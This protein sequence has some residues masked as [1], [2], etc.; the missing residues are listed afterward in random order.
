[1]KPEKEKRK[2]RDYLIQEIK[3]SG[4]PL[5]IEVS[6][7]LEKNYLVLNT[8]YYFDEE[9]REERN[10]DIYAIPRGLP[11]IDSKQRKNTFILQT[12]MAI[13]CKK[14]ET[15]AWIFY[16]RPNSSRWDKITGQYKTTVP[17]VLVGARSLSKLPHTFDEAL[18]HTCLGR[19]L[20]HD[21]PK[22]IAITYNEIKKQK[23]K[24]HGE[25]RRQIFGA[26]QQL[27][28]FSFYE[29]HR[30]FDKFP[31]ELE[32]SIEMIVMLFPVVV[33]DGD[34]FEVYFDTG[35]PR[36][37]RK[38]HILLATHNRCPYC[39]KVGGFLVDIVHYSYF[40][41]F[42]KTI[43]ND[44]LRIGKNTLKMYSKLESIAKEARAQVGN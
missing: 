38:N 9:E 27:V 41:K 30:H 36:L 32:G 4:Y 35:K 21:A 26:V 25:S 44:F 2:L 17:K 29:L 14:S 20:H 23:N 42:L 24:K 34:M 8:E 22:R 39:Q 3:K 43:E 40:S 18:E 33:F 5:E 7:L 12:N 19:G 15:H 28:K 11:K 31:K 37:R 6:R 13:E 10:I 16:T 1:M